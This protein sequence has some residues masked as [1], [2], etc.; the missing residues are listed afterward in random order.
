MNK[1]ILVCILA[2][3]LGDYYLQTEEISEKKKDSF[4]W[5]V[6][7]STLYMIPFVAIYIF[8]ENRHIFAIGMFTI[9]LS[10]FIIDGVKG[11]VH[12]YLKQRHAK[13]REE[14]FHKWEKYIY[15]L[16]Q[17]A[18]YTVI[19]V[20][21]YHCWCNYDVVVL[22]CICTMIDMYKITLTD[23]VKVFVII[24]SMYKPVN[25]TYSVLFSDFKPAENVKNGASISRSSKA[26]MGMIK[27]NG[28]VFQF[29]GELLD[30][31]DNLVEEK[32]K[33]KSVKKAGSYIGF[34]ERIIIIIFISLEAYSAIGFVLTAKS[35]A[36]YDNITKDQQF[37]E[38]FLIG[39]LYSMAMCLVVYGLLYYVL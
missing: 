4:K 10:H 21:S 8:M 35:V 26:V 16:D 33:S 11:F 12:K 30:L 9:V 24:V 14:R 7:H 6:V 3:L 38:Y 1:M 29:E 15:I 23:L 39:T 5:L 19:I 25:I 2:H 22:E 27:G 37:A 32:K 13:I 34:F 17:I 36:R 20:V 18:H 31:K 28:E